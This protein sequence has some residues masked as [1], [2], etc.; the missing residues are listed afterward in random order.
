MGH[1]IASALEKT[2]HELLSQSRT[3]ESSVEAQREMLD[4]VRA[5]MLEN[6]QELSQ[7]SPI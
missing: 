4:E 6:G 1:S 3:F 2:Q 7:A 5:K